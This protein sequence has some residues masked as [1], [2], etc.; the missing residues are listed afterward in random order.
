VFIQL[1]DVPAEMY[2]LLLQQA[3]S[4]RRTLSQQAI[5]VLTRGLEVEVDFKARRREILQDIRSSAPV[6][7]SSLSSPAKIDTRGQAPLKHGRDALWRDAGD[8]VGPLFRRLA[9]DN[10]GAGLQPAGRFL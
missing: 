9:G 1:T 3:G 2:P 5:V 10:R 8:A 4:E 6:G 7:G